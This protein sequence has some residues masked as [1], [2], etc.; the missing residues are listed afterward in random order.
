VLSFSSHPVHLLNG[1]RFFFNA[2]A[3]QRISVCRE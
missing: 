3:G 1:S 2:A